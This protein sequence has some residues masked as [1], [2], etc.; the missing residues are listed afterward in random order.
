MDTDRG[1]HDIDDG[2]RRADF[3]KVDVIDG[4]TMN[5]CFRLRQAS[6]DRD[7]GCFNLGGQ[8]GALD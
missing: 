6:K 1:G 4:D 3:V 7:A 2:I 8:F 5:F